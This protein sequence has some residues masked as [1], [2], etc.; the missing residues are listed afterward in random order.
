MTLFQILSGN[1]FIL[2]FVPL[3]AEPLFRKVYDATLDS[4]P[5]AY[6]LVRRGRSFET[7]FVNHASF[8]KKPRSFQVSAGFMFLCF[9][10]SVILF[11]QRKNLEA[12]SEELKDR[13]SRDTDYIVQE[14]PGR[15]ITDQSLG[16]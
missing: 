14:R 3:M 8:Y 15:N 12:F 4:F 11:G 13:G 2:A 5:S 1:Y 7:I 9:A 16:D 6:I 10:L